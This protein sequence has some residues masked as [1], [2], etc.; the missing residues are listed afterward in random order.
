MHVFKENINPT[1]LFQTQLYKG[2]SPLE[3]Q[4]DA[5]TKK[6]SNL[7]EEYKKNQ[8]TTLLKKI[9]SL[10]PDYF[11]FTTTAIQWL[12]KKNNFSQKQNKL[13]E[14]LEQLQ[15]E[16]KNINPKLEVLISNLLFAFRTKKRVFSHILATQ[17]ENKIYQN[18][19]EVTQE[20]FIQEVAKEP[21]ITFSSLISHLQLMPNEFSQN[22]IDWLS[23]SIR[24]E[25]VFLAIA[26][27]ENGEITLS[28]A[29]IDELAF[30]VADQSQLYYALSIQL[31]FIKK[32]ERVY[33]NIVFDEQ[34]I[35][36]Q[37]Q[38][39]DLGLHDLLNIS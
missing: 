32:K 23:A 29:I 18:K 10:V 26:M 11:D 15:A 3:K 6:I 2:Y 5:M 24:I 31:E 20:T 35:K 8:T 30:L 4:L 19:K 21:I 12:S 27:L 28:D 37:Q 38:L 25:I 33:K 9:G 14:E 39:A 17:N 7:F 1:Y 36:E 13:V 34:T 16:Q 22:Y